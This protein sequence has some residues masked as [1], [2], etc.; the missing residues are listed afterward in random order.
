MCFVYF[1]PFFFEGDRANQPLYI[2]KTPTRKIINRIAASIQRSLA[3][4]SVYP[5]AATYSRTAS[6]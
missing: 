6:G 2:R 1:K 4:I 3:D 5:C